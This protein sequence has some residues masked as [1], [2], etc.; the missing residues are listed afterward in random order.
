MH[1]QHSHG[2]VDVEV[3]ALN[4]RREFLQGLL[5]NQHEGAACAQRDAM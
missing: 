2:G 5:E 1:V 3:G 4:A